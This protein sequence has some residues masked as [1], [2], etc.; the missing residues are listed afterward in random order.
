MRR[1][2]RLLIQFE[3]FAKFLKLSRDVAWTVGLLRWFQS[4][5][6]LIKK[7]FCT[8]H[9]Y[10]FKVVHLFEVALLSNFEGNSTS[11]SYSKSP[12]Y[13]IS[14]EIPH[15]P[16]ISSH[17]IIQVTRIML[18]KIILSSQPA[19]TVVQCSTNWVTK[20]FQKYQTHRAKKVNI[21]I[22]KLSREVILQTRN[23]SRARWRQI[24]DEESLK[25]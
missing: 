17:P 8:E 21:F 10:F 16:F 12:Y 24:S 19:T 15:R 1:C 18:S 9:R 5:A 20:T 13:Y 23:D 11:P 6:V 7:E 4:D 3:F 2:R 14:R 25:T 22:S